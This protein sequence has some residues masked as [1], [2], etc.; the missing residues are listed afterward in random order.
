LR[1]RLEF[2]SNDDILLPIG[3]NKYIQALIYNLFSEKVRNFVHETGFKSDKKF[4]LFCFSSI[5]EIGEYFKSLKIFNFGR[6]ISFYISSPVES[7]LNDLIKGLFKGEKFKLGENDIFLSSVMLNSMVI[8]SSSIIVNALTP[9]EVHKTFKTN[10]KN[11]TIYFSPF[12][13]EFERLININLK[14]KWKAFTN[15]ELS[16][17]KRIAI[18]PLF[19]GFSNK[20]VVYYGFGKKRYVIEGWKGTY[21]LLGNPTLLNFLYDAGLGSKNSQGFGF[22]EKKGE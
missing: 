11:K 18:K 22:I 2:I 20:R 16:E 13:Y 5:L 10:G 7:L 14:N 21:Q 8:K 6:K 4:S 15:E 3:F 12:D 1:L 17:K 9:I 19:E